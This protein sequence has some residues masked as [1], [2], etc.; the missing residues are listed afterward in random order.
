MTLFPPDNAFKGRQ[1]WFALISLAMGGLVLLGFVVWSTYNETWQEAELTAE[2]YAQI[3]DTRLDAALRRVDSN[4]QA[5]VGQ[6]PAEALDP[7]NVPL[8]KKQVEA[9]LGRFQLAFPE[10]AGFRIVDAKGDLLYLSGGGDFVNLADRDYFIALQ[11]GKSTE[12]LFSQVLVSRKNA[13]SVMVAAR[14]IRAEDGRFLGMVS[15]P[16]D[17]GYF[18]QQSKSIRLGNGGVWA[19]R[20]LDDHT[21]VLRQPP[22]PEKINQPLSA[23]NQ[24]VQKLSNGERTGSFRLIA[25]TDGVHRMY[26][27]RSL[28]DFPFY[29]VAGVSNADINAEWQQR[30]LIMGGLGGSLFLALSLAL[31]WLFRNQAQELR[32]TEALLRNQAQL[33]EAQRLARIGSWELDR[34]T[35]K[36]QCSDEFFHIFEHDPATS[37]ASYHLFLDRVHPDDREA[38]DKA[39]RGSIENRTPYEIEHRLLMPDGRIKV[40]RE[41][42]E[43]FYDGDGKPIRS[44]G[45]AQDISSIRQMESQMQLLAIAFQ[46]SGEAILITDCKNAIVTVNPAFTALTGY[47]LE[48]AVGKNPRFLS[49]GRNSPEDYAAMWQSIHDRGYWQGEIWDRR[50]DGGIYPKWMSVSIIRDD[51]GKIN[52]HIAHFTDISAERAAEEKLHHIAHHD[53][54]TG[55]PNR[56]SLSGRVQQA[57]ALA[58]RDGGRVALLFIDLDRFKVVNDTLGHHVGDE[59]LVEVAQRLQECIRD[60][61]VVARLGGDE[62][63]IMLTGLE[64]TAAIAVVAEKVVLAIG[65]PYLIEGHDLYT[66]PSIG[67]AIFPTDGETVDVLMKNAD[68]AMYHAKSAGRNNFQF[69]DAKMNEVALER[70]SIEHSLRQALAHEEFC[71]HFQPIIDVASG[72]VVEVE[73]LVRWIH[74]Q[75]GMIPPCKFIGIAEETGLIQ[76]LG[77][78]VFWNACRLLADFNEAGLTGVKMGIN[79]SALQMRTGNLPVL[80]SGA[81]QALNLNPQDLVFEITESVAMQRPEETVAILDLLHNMGITLAI[82][83]FGTGYSSLSYLKSFPIDHIKLDRSFVEEIGQG[84]GSSVICDA[85]IGLAHN[86]GLKLVAEGVETEEQ[87]NYLRERN[88]DLVQGYFF[89]R[90]VP[91]KELIAFIRQRNG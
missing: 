10:V 1:L 69:F 77:E 46:F 13:Q 56:L 87:F 20:R 76:P 80:A 40:I 30:A 52:Y 74:P 24:V 23:N 8:L 43:T 66:S 90:P 15:A 47:T 73:A 34:V 89:S 49:A 14:A 45:T 22:M 62:F 48:E 65:S 16:L 91:A 27:F 82:D 72:R 32:A 44:L 64:H 4:L 81:I 58:R 63:V 60:S 71:L 29:V 53:S 61:D 79:I 11:N 28:K 67:V 6:L 57:L 17:L 33:R 18:V 36:S 31:I 9:N 70:L 86:L 84:G 39:Y 54:L 7:S 37:V 78:W 51:E 85:T 42:G 25:Q 38:V 88:C 12:T 75:Q 83:D 2:S 35:G 59:L 3:L 41:C 55:L 21:L 26:T 5:I 68:A 19:I 50:K